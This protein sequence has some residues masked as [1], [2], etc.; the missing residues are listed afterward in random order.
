MLKTGRS[1]QPPRP[2]LGMSTQDPEGQLVVARLTPGGPASSAGVQVGDL[3]LGIGEKRVHGLAELFR[4]VWRQG[5]AGVD[6]PLTLARGGDV[7]RITVRS[8]DRNDFL[9]KPKLH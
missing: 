4:T 9:R 6:V 5:A 3:V 7:I 8:A 2:W 1:A